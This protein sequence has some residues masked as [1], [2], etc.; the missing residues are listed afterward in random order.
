M[1]AALRIFG[2]GVPERLPGSSDIRSILISG[3]MGIG[4][5]ILFEPTLRAFRN[6]FPAAHLTVLLDHNA[7]SRAIFG[8]TGAV[9]EIIEITPGSRSRRLWQGAL[10]ARRKWDVG[11]VRFNGLTYE[12]ALAAVFAR[13]RYRVGHVSS[14]RYWHELDWIF[15]LPVPMREY[16]HEVD[17]YLALAERLGIQPARRIPELTVS[18]AAA[19]TARDTLTGL[20]VGTDGPLVAIQPGTSPLQKWKRWPLGHWREVVGRLTALGVPVVG[21]GSAEERELVQSVC[22]G[23][24]ARN[25]AGLGSLEES[26]GV[27]QRSDVLVCTDSGLMH[28]AAAVGRPVVA[29]FG[30]TDRTRTTPVGPSHR[31]LTPP[32]CHP[33]VPCLSPNGVLSAACTPDGCLR[34]ITPDVVVDAVMDLLRARRSVAIG[35]EP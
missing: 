17:R 18:A 6:H 19:A 35:H 12:L 11:V 7:P 14:G 34:S 4:N 8:W 5:A 3:T 10:L 30:P 32:G 33:R 22:E 31:V 26:A 20:C 24:P 23:T 15:N 28:V 29:I 1:S 25:A 21:L 16:D 9:D 2:T 27:L 13:I